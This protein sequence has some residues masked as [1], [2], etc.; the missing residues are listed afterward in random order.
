MDHEKNMRGRALYFFLIYIIRG[1]IDDSDFWLGC[2]FE[3]TGIQV[4]PS[5]THP[6]TL[7]SSPHI[8]TLSHHLYLLFDMISV[9]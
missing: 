9:T 5:T 2:I 8:F 4:D 1:Y 3:A 7:I 6:L